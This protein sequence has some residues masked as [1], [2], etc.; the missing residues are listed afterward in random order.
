MDN[1]I[2]Q[3]EELTKQGLAQL[4]GMD[5]EQ[6]GEFMER[7]SA[8]IKTITAVPLTAAQ[9]ALYRDRVR[10]VLRQDPVF[11]AKM[12]ALRNEAR[13]HLQK[14]EAGRTQRHA[15]DHAYDGESFFFDKRK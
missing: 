13:E 6:L 5:Y 12:E 8:I 14:F 10:E 11:K 1:L 7:R 4:A 2:Q 15:Y 9:Q 3:L